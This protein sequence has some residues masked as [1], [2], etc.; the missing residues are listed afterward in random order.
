[1]IQKKNQ[2]SD[3]K[4]FF[5]ENFKISYLDTKDDLPKNVGIIGQ[6]YNMCY[7]ACIELLFKLIRFRKKIANKIFKRAGF[8]LA[9]LERRLLSGYIKEEELFDTFFKIEYYE[10]EASLSDALNSGVIDFCVIPSKIY[11]T[12][13]HDIIELEEYKDLIESKEII[14]AAAITKECNKLFFCHHCNL[15]QIKTIYTTGINNYIAKDLI[16]EKFNFTD[17]EYKVRRHTRLSYQDNSIAHDSSGFICNELYSSKLKADEKLQSR[18][19]D[20][21][22]HMV[23]FRLLKYKTYRNKDDNARPPSLHRRFKQM[24]YYFWRHRTLKAILTIII[25]FLL[26]LYSLSY[27]SDVK[28]ISVL[29]NLDIAFSG[30]ISFVFSITIFLIFYLLNTTTK[31]QMRLSKVKG[32]WLLYTTPTNRSP[33]AKERDPF[34][35]R[36]PR[37]VRIYFANRKHLEFEIFM[38]NNEGSYLK[39]E[40]F[41]WDAI[42]LKNAKIVITY[43][44]NQ[45]PESKKKHGFISG[46]S[47][48]DCE[49]EFES[50]NLYEMTGHF[51]FK[52]KL[53][54]GRLDYFRIADEQDFALLKA[55]KFIEDIRI[56]P[57]AP[58]DA[59]VPQD[60]FET[61]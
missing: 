28:P 14:L 44:N 7:E 52:S 54:N 58:T 45:I 1:M 10:N 59:S 31:V 8:D 57:L 46:I 29:P 60:S 33:E 32:Y 27:S 11:N 25:S 15:D 2:L 6:K 21:D 30:I 22:K 55:S 12:I 51:Y 19:I 47:E 18:V 36:Y 53:E 20:T 23:E 42:D 5:R 26:Y 49:I 17:V 3:F 34:L 24:L 9:E 37:V 38:L 48:L 50:S 40:S 41:F 56:T 61:Y 4:K 13:N 16:N 39:S 43:S 35:Y